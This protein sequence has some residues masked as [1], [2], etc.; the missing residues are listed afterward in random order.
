MTYEQLLGIVERTIE[1]AAPTL[2]AGAN[3]PIRTGRLRSAIKVKETN[4][5]WLIYLDEGSMT[6]DQWNAMFPNGAKLSDN[7]TGVAPYAETVDSYNH[8]WIRVADLLAQQIKSALGSA[9]EG[10]SA[11]YQNR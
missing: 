7:P 6:E 11:N 1:M 2:G 10:Y 3:V 9:V 5:G 8:Y 4:D